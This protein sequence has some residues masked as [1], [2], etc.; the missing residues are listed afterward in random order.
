MFLMDGWRAVF[1]IGIAL[2]KEMEKTLLTMDMVDMCNYFRDNV[3][4]EK[5]VTNFR[6]FSEASRI[7]VNSILV[8]PFLCANKF[9]FI[10]SQS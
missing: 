5:V 8:L 6:L 2:L 10:D 7:R 4:K 1:R 3:R 9:Y